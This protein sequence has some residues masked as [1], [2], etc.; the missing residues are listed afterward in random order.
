MQQG[1]NY[2]TCDISAVGKIALCE[3]MGRESS[4]V[5]IAANQ[6]WLVQNPGKLPSFK[7]VIIKYLLQTGALLRK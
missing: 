4:S 1:T 5:T 3:G 6:A 7:I 2:N